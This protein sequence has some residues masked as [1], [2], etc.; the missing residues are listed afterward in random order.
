[1]VTSIFLG[2][3]SAQ[4]NLKTNDKSPLNSEEAGGS[5]NAN[6]RVIK[7]ESIKNISIEGGDV[8]RK[9]SDNYP[10]MKSFSER[11]STSLSKSIKEQSKKNEDEL[12]NKKIDIDS[13]IKIDYVKSF[14][15]IYYFFEKFI[16]SI[17]S[18]SGFQ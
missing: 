14:S 1:M 2:V 5:E 8:V 17:F 15:V 18:E 16:Q 11:R 9:F 13:I 7:F 3:K 10:N 6:M 12:A 4:D